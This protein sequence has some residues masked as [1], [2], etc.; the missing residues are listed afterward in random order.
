MGAGGLEPLLVVGSHRTTPIDP[1]PGSRR[2]S[3]LATYGCGSFGSDW[4]ER[5]TVTMGHFPGWYPDPSG[6][7]QERYFNSDAVSTQRVRDNGF[8]SMDYPATVRTSAYPTRSASSDV[9]DQTLVAQ[10][11]YV[12]AREVAPALMPGRQGVEAALVARQTPAVVQTAIAPVSAPASPPPT[13]VRRPRSRWLV[14]ATCVL[15]ALLGA[16]IAAGIEQHSVA[17]TWMKA[18]HTEVRKNAALRAALGSS[19]GKVGSLKHQVSTLQ[20][21]L[22]AVSNQKQ[23]AL[24]QNAT[25][26]TSLQDASAVATDLNSC[27]NDTETILNS[28]TTVS[29]IG[30]FPSS[31]QIAAAQQVCNSA[32]SEEASL[33]QTLSGGL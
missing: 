8:E 1:A 3:S 31:S 30:S 14:A 2:C 13:P 18:D 16:A 33:Q 4:L 6:R 12:E 25:L 26:T 27:I 5:R 23:Q 7:H 24:D 11:E 29:R 21:Q 28:V 15:A 20:I 17:E 22:L 32:Q 9:L 10:I 19:H